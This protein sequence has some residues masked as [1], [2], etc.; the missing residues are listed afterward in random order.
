MNLYVHAWLLHS[1]NPI[2][3]NQE[4]INLLGPNSQHVQLHGTSS[5]SYF[6]TTVGL[7]VN[8]QL[9]GH[10][11]QW[12]LQLLI[13]DRSSKADNTM[14][15]EAAKERSAISLVKRTSSWSTCGTLFIISLSDMRGTLT[16]TL[17]MGPKGI[18]LTWTMVIAP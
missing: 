15:L 8:R 6:Q 11:L 13:Y 18:F 10:P 1:V 17:A 7:V 5:P 14:L 9:Q 3:G 12:H 2:E 16:T 4:G